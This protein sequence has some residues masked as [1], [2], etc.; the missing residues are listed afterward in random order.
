MLKKDYKADLAKTTRG[1]YIIKVSE[2][3]G[4]D[5]VGPEQ[6]EVTEEVLDYLIA[7]KRIEKKKEVED[8]RNTAAFGF[9]DS[10]SMC[11]LIYF[12]ISV[13]DR[14]SIMSSAGAISTPG[15]E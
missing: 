8:Y 11:D 3:Y 1:T 4:T 10:F 6:V 7:Q 15:G 2:F 13:L 5:F 12:C 9:D 14:R